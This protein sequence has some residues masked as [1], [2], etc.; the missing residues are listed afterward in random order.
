MS[1]ETNTNI[2]PAKEHERLTQELETIIVPE[3]V[4]ELPEKRMIVN[5]PR[6]NKP[7]SRWVQKH[8]S[9]GPTIT[10]RHTEP[11][12]T[13][14]C[15]VR[16]RRSKRK[17]KLKLKTKREIGTHTQI[18]VDKFDK[19]VVEL[20]KQELVKTEEKKAELHLRYRKLVG[21]VTSLFRILNDQIEQAFKAA[22]ECGEDEPSVEYLVIDELERLG[23]SN[24]AI[25]LVLD[26]PTM[27]ELL[28]KGTT[29]K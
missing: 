12:R 28:D 2:V 7:G 16:K 29:S 5:C 24:S 9:G 14:I 17:L 22:K 3:P 11:D 4:K 15:L 8:R 21:D 10:I 13:R 19:K 1:S 18:T 23:D 20:A 6:C 25:R 27:K 26:Y